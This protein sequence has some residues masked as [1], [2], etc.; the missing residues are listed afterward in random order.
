[1]QRSRIWAARLHYT[2]SFF[3]RLK[4]SDL[5]AGHHNRRGRGDTD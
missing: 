1:M 4:L 5:S 3:S 2:I